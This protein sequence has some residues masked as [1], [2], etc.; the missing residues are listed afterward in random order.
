MNETTAEPAE[1]YAIFRKNLGK[2]CNV[3]DLLDGQ[4]INADPLTWF[5]AYELCYR[6]NREAR[7]AANKPIAAPA[8]CPD[9]ARLRAVMEQIAHT[10]GEWN[11]Q[12]IVSAAL[13]ITGGG[14]G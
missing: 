7:A 11:I 3:V 4:P 1:R 5:E 13:G 8:P 10:R 6:L 2:Y 9:C 12:R 14:N